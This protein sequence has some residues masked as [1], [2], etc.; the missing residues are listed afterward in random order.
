MN[1]P[2]LLFVSISVTQAFHSN[3]SPLSLMKRYLYNSRRS[4]TLRNRYNQQRNLKTD[5]VVDFAVQYKWTQIQK[6]QTADA[7]R[8]LKAQVAEY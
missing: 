4:N 6:R 5:S 7:F 3:G 8:K 1:F 2:I